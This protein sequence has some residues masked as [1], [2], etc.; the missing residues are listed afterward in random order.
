[1]VY[2]K[3]VDAFGSLAFTIPV[4]FLTC[5]DLELAIFSLAA[6]LAM[7]G[8]GRAGASVSLVEVAPR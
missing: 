4:G 5:H 6:W 7:S 1:M 8:F 2:F 3:Y